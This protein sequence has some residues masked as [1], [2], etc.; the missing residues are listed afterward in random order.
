MNKLDEELEKNYRD[1]INSESYA[2]PFTAEELRR[3]AEFQHLIQKYRDKRKAERLKKDK[4][5]N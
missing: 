3:Q 5:K 4:Q 2:G 1:R